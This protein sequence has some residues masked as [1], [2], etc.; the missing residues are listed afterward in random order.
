MANREMAR[1]LSFRILSQVI[2]DHGSKFTPNAF[3][4]F[5]ARFVDASRGNNVLCIDY[6]MGTGK[7]LTAA[8][9]ISRLLSDTMRIEE[10]LRKT[11][12]QSLIAQLPRPYIVGNWS[13]IEAF[14]DELMRPAFGIIS[15]DEFTDL[16]KSRAAE[17]TTQYAHMR[18]A[19]ARR[20]SKY[21]RM[22]SY[23]KMFNRYFRGASS[24][25][26]KDEASLL[27]A[28]EKKEVTVD[29]VIAL[30][31]SGSILVVDEV[32]MLYSGHGWN[33]YG[34]LLDHI[35][36]NEAI[37][38]LVTVMLSGTFLNSSPIEMI[39]LYNLIRDRGSK[40]ILIDDFFDKELIGG[41][42][43]TY[44]PKKSREEELVHLFDGKVVSYRIS[45]S[46]DFP[47]VNFAGTLA[48]MFKWF[49]ITRCHAS[50]YQWEQYIA[51]Y[52]TLIH[53]VKGGGR[54]VMTSAAD[55]SSSAAAM[56]LADASS[57]AARGEE[58]TSPSPSASRGEAISVSAAEP[59]LS[60]SIEEALE[61]GDE[62][63]DMMA[64][65][66]VLPTKEEWPQY[67]V[68]PIKGSTEVYSGSWLRLDNLESKF[69]AIPAAFIHHLLDVIAS[70]SGEKV[71]AHHRRLEK[72]GLLQYAEAL[73]E[74]GFTL[75]GEGAREN[76]ICV[77]C[78]KPL[79]LHASMETAASAEAESALA[80]PSSTAAAVPGHRKEIVDHKF[81]PATFA[82]LT[83]R[84]SFQERQH[85]KLTYNSSA[86]LLNHRIMCL[87][88]SGV[89]EK[90]I[91]LKATN[92]AI[93]L[94]VFPGIP[95]WRQFVSRIARHG[96]H[97]EL[98]SDKRWV[99]VHTMVISPPIGSKEKFSRDEFRYFIRESNDEMASHLWSM[100]RKRS[101]NCPFIPPENRGMPSTT[102]DA[103]SAASSSSSRRNESSCDGAAV[104]AASSKGRDVDSSYFFSLYQILHISFVRDIIRRCWAESPIWTL[105]DLRETI[106]SD[107][108]RKV[109][110]NMSYTSDVAI[111]EAII[112][113]CSNQECQL[114]SVGE[115]K[116]LSILKPSFL[117]RSDIVLAAG[118][119]RRGPR[120][121]TIFSTPISHHGASW[122]PIGR[123]EGTRSEEEL[124]RIVAQ[125]GA[126]SGFRE[127][128][129]LFDRIVGKAGI[130]TILRKDFVVEG[131]LF[132]LLRK[133]YCIVWEGDDESH[134]LF[135]RNRLRVI[136][137]NAS[138]KDKRGRQAV[139][140]A[141]GEEEK[142]EKKEEKTKKETKKEK[143]RGTKKTPK[144]KTK[145]KEK[146]KGGVVVDADDEDDDAAAT[147][148]D[149]PALC[150]L[151]MMEEAAA[152]SSSKKKVKPRVKKPSEKVQ[153]TL[154]PIG[155]IIGNEYHLY[156]GKKWEL[157]SMP[158]FDANATTQWKICAIFSPGA[159]IT[160]GRWN[161]RTKIRPSP[162]S[163]DD[164]RRVQS[165][166]ACLSLSRSQVDEYSTILGIKGE[167]GKTV[168]CIMLEK[169]LLERQL[170]VEGKKYRFIYTPF[171]VPPAARV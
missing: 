19:F 142:E 4:L 119:P 21:V 18:M 143:E 79:A 109:P 131:P 24:L 130:T 55:A 70:H 137:I 31:L 2:I 120:A 125:I 22:A 171:E 28:I 82:L 111:C 105:S 148:A 87:L 42:A 140:T 168:N 134:I 102:A 150:C 122:Q 67:S 47:A 123:E 25:A 152:V 71:V 26:V 11:G 45:P 158:L 15:L 57:A 16:M 93:A 153:P 139:A 146:R 114:S 167:K 160:N 39:F 110:H 151:E 53:P 132:G 103:T 106:L 107:R 49:R 1:D 8:L 124:Y 164:L 170:S 20:I 13:S 41:Q 149:G 157:R 96:T 81:V 52:E 126:I 48:K 9:V 128:S 23:Q 113:L 58:M 43:Y 62:E 30:E 12:R 97:R 133:A 80:E 169:A 121:L 33:T 73:K 155:F 86:N 88:L 112:D 83:G 136:E 84:I 7:T 145:T 5:P 162:T 117:Y 74:N 156:R 64:R 108:I 78:G 66:F 104:V 68:S 118:I 56:T 98:P 38:N 10:E 76:A 50:P 32:Q 147:A 65:D 85:I 46:K 34:F 94:G 100:V 101:V 161:V 116:D 3:Q 54:S 59:D 29:P 154:K 135:T 36:Q 27:A 6:D 138:K 69:G 60:P 91:T 89:G 95:A 51:S 44:K 144:E 63:D 165:G 40:K 99:D 90:G 166:M 37:R 61:E 115:M 35:R 127:K 159:A 17:D 77:I 72:G 129:S 163:V 75:F 92:Y 141:K 14:E